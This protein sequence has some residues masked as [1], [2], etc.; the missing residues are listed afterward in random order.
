MPS[1]TQKISTP[2]RNVN[3]YVKSDEFPSFDILVNGK[4]YETYPQNR[5]NL[6]DE[7]SSNRSLRTTRK[8]QN[9]NSLQRAIRDR[10]YKTAEG[11]SYY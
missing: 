10:M 1:L 3:I 11:V 6:S 8:V 9:P 4:K 5:K 2:S 7:F